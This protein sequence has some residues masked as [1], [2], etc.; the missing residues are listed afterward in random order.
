VWAPDSHC[1]AEPPHHA[2]LSAGTPTRYAAAR[3]T[4]VSHWV[5]HRTLAA[6]FNNPLATTRGRNHLSANLFTT[7]HTLL[8]GAQVGPV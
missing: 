1:K 6:Q 7:P 4:E 5:E 8:Q 3:R 2:G